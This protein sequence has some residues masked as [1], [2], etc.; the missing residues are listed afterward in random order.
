MFC[1]SPRKSG[2][3]SDDDGT[4]YDEQACR[5]TAGC[6]AASAPVREHATPVRLDDG[7]FAYELGETLGVGATG[8]VKLGTHK[9]TGEKAAV[10]IISSSLFARKPNLMR[11]VLRECAIMKSIDHT[12]VVKLRGSWCSPT[13]SVYL[14]LELV[15]GGELFGHILET[16]KQSE[17]TARR[18]FG[19]LV[20]GLAYCH[21][22]NICHRDIKPEN[23]LIDKRTGTLKL[24]DFGFAQWMQ[25][26]SD[27]SDG[28]VETSCGSPHYASP[29]V[30]KGG[31]YVGQSADTWSCGVVLYALLTGGL[32]FDSSN[33]QRLLRIVSKGEFLVPGWLSEDA[34][35]LLA[36]MLTVDPKKRITMEEVKQHPWFHPSQPP[37]PTTTTG[38]F[39][40]NP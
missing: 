37:P 33:M 6:T 13:G 8:K 10:K 39:P 24:A 34:R 18:L 30:I 35:D 11:S 19:E 22:K 16:G 5:A 27:G 14:V 38:A 20:D 3:D 2:G 15:D 23:M 9:I 21:A 36:R 31:R 7:A 4:V 32:P 12:N 40:Y 29:E 25:R 17:P 28:W 1:G 26:R